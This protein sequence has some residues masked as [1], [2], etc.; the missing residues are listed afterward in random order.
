MDW[1]S[2]TQYP[3]PAVADRLGVG[4]GWIDDYS[5]EDTRT[6]ARLYPGREG[7]PGPTPT[8][9]P[10]PHPVAPP[11][12]NPVALTW[13]GVAQPLTLDI[14]R[15]R[16]VD[17][18]VRVRGRRP[19]TPTLSLRPN[20]LDWVGFRLDRGEPERG[21]PAAWTVVLYMAPGRYEVA[22]QFLGKGPVKYDVTAIRK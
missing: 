3:L 14:D 15:S 9:D 16:T 5:P 4:V 7:G 19:P 11:G 12:G 6:V 22:A 21:E 13:T 8:P 1:T 10:P 17:L 20:G 2:I 18:R